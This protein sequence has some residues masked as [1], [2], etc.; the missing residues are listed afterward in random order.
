LEFLS[1]SFPLDLTAKLP[2]SARLLIMN[3]TI[4]KGTLGDLDSIVEFQ[5]EMA[6]ESE[7]TELDRNTVTE[8]VRNGLGDEARALY[9]VA[10]DEGG[11]AIG[12]LML[13]K[14]WS[15]WNNSPYYWI[16][17]VY[18]SPEYR[19]KGV[20]RAL[21]EKAKEKAREEGAAAVRLYVDRHNEKAQAVYNS[22]GMHECHYLMY[23]LDS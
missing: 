12:S 9:L 19:R 18:V 7:G 6:R 21:F 5:L 16:Q 20:F 1:P 4:Q 3:V 11:K 17:S 10:H 13:T 22:L 23:E 14:E 2:S 15:D 8:G